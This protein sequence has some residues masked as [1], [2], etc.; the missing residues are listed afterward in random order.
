MEKKKNVFEVSVEFTKEEFENAIDKAFDKK[1][2]DIKMD[3]FRK[4][5]VPK[6]LYI[7][8]AG[9]ESLYMDAIDVL[10]PEAYDRVFKDGKYQPIIDPKVDLKKMDENGVEFLFTITTMPE[11]KISKY[12]GLEVKKPSV[13]V[14]KAEVEKEIESLLEKYSELEIKENGA[15]ENKDIA[16]ID[17]EGFKDGV[18][19]EGG[20]GEN[21]SLEIGSNTF[22]PGFE[23][24]LIGMKNGE[25][26]EIEVTFPEE[27]QAE[28]LKGAK[29][30]FK[31]KV[32]EIKTKVQRELDED[33]FED[34]GM[35]GVNSKETLEEEIK[36][37]IKA[38]K[39]MDAENEYIDALLKAVAKNTKVDIPEELIEDEINH[40]I[41]RF[42]QQ[43]KMQGISLDVY[44]EITRSKE[45]DL[46][47]NMKE[48]ATNH[49]LYRFILD[50]IK[51]K[52]KITVEE[53]EIEE[54]FEN[55][56]KQYNVSTEEIKKMYGDPHM[57]SY[58]LEARKV[59]DFLKENN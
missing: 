34:L 57:M 38:H 24:Q 23:E 1:K 27:Y 46:R 21:Y 41:K 53:K 49:I 40:M 50:T 36:A 20:K 32:N 12:T 10:L 42:E 11:V 33:F 56:A 26:R 9:K 31:V 15:V 35:E 5:K 6:D 48:E 2:N 47:N 8:K 17:F 30:T 28:E 39:E 51:E 19:F 3:G 25:E 58:E 37:N 55:L 16:V 52:E 4:G 14:T 7:K 44:Y 45:E 13:K 22:I 29:A 18:A 43:I 54:E 59:I